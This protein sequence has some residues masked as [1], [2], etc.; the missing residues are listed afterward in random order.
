[1]SSQSDLDLEI[2]HEF[3]MESQENLDQLDQ[4]LVALEQSPGSR[5]LLASIFRTI[6]TIKGTS[7]F[8]AFQ[9]LEKLTH[10]G[11]SLLS[12]LRDG[13]ATMTPEAA[14]ALLRMVDLVRLMLAN[15]E[16]DGTDG[17]VEY[18][19]VVVEINAV[20]EAQEAAANAASDVPDP[21]PA[22]AVEPVAEPQRPQAARIL[23]EQPEA[24]EFETPSADVATAV[25]APAAAAPKP[26]TPRKKAAAAPKPSPVAKAQPAP[27]PAPGTGPGT[28]HTGTST[29]TRTE[30]GGSTRRRRPSRGRCRRQQAERVEHP[31]GRRTARTARSVDRRARPG[32]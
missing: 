7:G 22:A 13:A 5:E 17:E 30:A 27:E 31:S 9:R 3:L 10:A 15:I 11:E 21:T 23:P 14:T 25:T 6:H 20:M 4:D 32:A 28:R 19:S 18:D 16:N 12:R 26:R 8:L 29:S 24:P 2:V 1:M